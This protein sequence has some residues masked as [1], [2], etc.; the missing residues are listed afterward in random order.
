M[1]D[2]ELTGQASQSDI[3]DGSDESKARWQTYYSGGLMGAAE[4]VLTTRGSGATPSFEA[5]GVEMT[6][7]TDGDHG[8]I[9]AGATDIAGTVQVTTGT[10]L[11]KTIYG[12][13]VDIATLADDH[14]IGAYAAGGG[15]NPDNYANLAVFRPHVGDSTSGNVRVNNGGTIT[16]GTVSYPDITEPVELCVL[17]DYAGNYL[18]AGHTGFYIDSDPREGATPNVNISDTP[19][20]FAEFGIAYASE[21]NGNDFTANYME[22][23]HRP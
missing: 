22:V 11:I 6:S 12:S 19:G 18:T 21:G 10:Y 17:I 4:T 9:S 1:P 13:G 15:D 2:Y 20:P 5:S 7:G 14:V 8:S 3:A 16:D 23:S